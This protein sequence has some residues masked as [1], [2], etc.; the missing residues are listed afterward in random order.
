MNMRYSIQ[1]TAYERDGTTRASKKVTKKR[2]VPW[3]WLARVILMV[4]K[5]RWFHGGSVV[6]TSTGTVMMTWELTGN[7]MSDGRVHIYEHG[8]GSKRKG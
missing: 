3:L 8:V 1:Y 7:I 4:L 2:G 5:E 6:D